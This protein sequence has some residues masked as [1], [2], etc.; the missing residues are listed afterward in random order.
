M[1][2]PVGRQIYLMDNPLLPESLHPA[3]VKPRLL[4][5]WG[6]TRASTCS[7]RTCPRIVAARNRE[8]IYVTGPWP[9]RPGVPISS[10]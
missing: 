2:L 5:H 7:T 10:R 1:Q 8:I 9:R 3:Q 6:T 4:G